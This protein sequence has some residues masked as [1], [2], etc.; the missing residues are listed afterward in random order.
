[1]SKIE[2]KAGKKYWNELW[3]EHKVPMPFDPS[4]ITH[5]N[6]RHRCRHNLFQKVF[7]DINTK[8]KKLIE[9]GGG[10]SIWL[11]YFAKE[12]GF[13]ISSIDYSEAGCQRLLRILEKADVKGEVIC[14][15]AFAPPEKMYG[16]YDAVISFGVVEH[17]DDTKTVFKEFSKYLKPG[18]LLITLIPHTKGLPGILRRIINKDNHAIHV[19]LNVRDLFLATEAP[20]L[21]VVTCGYLVFFSLGTSILKG[22]DPDNLSYRIKKMLV[23][24]LNNISMGLALIDDRFKIHFPTNRITSPMVYLVAKKNI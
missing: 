13:N 22:L 3:D 6:Y 2:D 9:I 23:H 17:F 18:G 10:G 14:G 20:Q 8:G 16:I 7:S 19:P 15:D 24:S 4:I 1:M 21:E 12:F 5:H 11:P